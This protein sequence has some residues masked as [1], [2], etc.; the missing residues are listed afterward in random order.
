[1]AKGPPPAPIGTVGVGYVALDDVNE[2]FVED[3]ATV[4]EL[5]DA[6]VDDFDVVV[7]LLAEVEDIFDVV[8]EVFVV[9]GISFGA[10]FGAGAP[11]TPRT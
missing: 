8:V 9:D 2:T 1:M 4:D 11:L 3:K 10:P 5:F 7:K 6:D